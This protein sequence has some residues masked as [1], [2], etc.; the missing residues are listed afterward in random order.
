MNGEQHAFLKQIIIE[1]PLFVQVKGDLGPVIQQQ[2]V[3]HQTLLVVAGGKG[4]LLINHQPFKL[5]TKAVFLIPAGAAIEIHNRQRYG[6]QL[7]LLS[8]ELFRQSKADAG[9]RLY[10]KDDHFPI[11]GQLRLAKPGRVLQMVKQLYERMMVKQEGNG[12]Q[13][14]FELQ[15]L[16]QELLLQDSLHAAVSAERSFDRSIK[17]LQNAFHTDITL[18]NLAERAGL[19]ASYYSFLFAKK[20]GKGPIEY[21]TELRMNRAKERLLLS[22]DKIQQ[23]AREVG[24]KDEFYFSRRFKAQQG[25][26]PSAY[27]RHHPAHI[28]PLSFAYTDHLFALGMIPLAAQVNEQYATISEHIELPLERLQSLKQWREQLLK[29]KPELIICKDNISVAMRENLSD[30]A[31]IIAFPW[32]E[33]DVYGHLS[34]LAKLTNKQKAAEEWMEHHE[35]K[36]ALGRKKVAAIAGGAAVTICGLSDGQYRIYGDRNMGHVFYRSLQLNP[37][38]KLRGEMDKHMPGTGL[39]WME[40][41]AGQLCEYESD[42]LIFIAK[43]EADRKAMQLQLQPGGRWCSHKAV[44]NKRVFQL[45]L[46]KWVVYAPLALDQQLDEAVSLF[47]NSR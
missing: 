27:S 28:V 17:Y 44:R 36:A 33:M 15:H 9:V 3:Q 32:M 7:Y 38:E 8:F 24:Y 19:N 26:S 16:L 5:S 42:Y 43:T 21:L 10:E 11:R 13:N 29:V 2:T 41:D 23:I 22:G 40:I 35:N 37:S 39:D 12:L 34:A 47:L 18:G 4:E 30:V 25:L 31:P 6:L 46:G 14:S 20:M 45:N 1:I